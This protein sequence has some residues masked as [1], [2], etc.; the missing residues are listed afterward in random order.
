MK[1]QGSGWRRGG[2]H[3]PGDIFG[4]YRKPSS[5]VSQL[6]NKKAASQNSPT[7]LAHKW[8]GIL[9]QHGGDPF[10]GSHHSPEHDLP[11]PQSTFRPLY[12]PPPTGAAGGWAADPKSFIAC[13][14]PGGMD[15]HGHTLH[16]SPVFLPDCDT[17][18]QKGG[19]VWPRLT[20]LGTDFCLD[21]LHLSS[22]RGFPK[23]C[24]LFIALKVGWDCEPQRLKGVPGKDPH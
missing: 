14:L 4:A 3:T 9:E 11:D 24:V 8:R 19:E 15:S 23:F 17:V 6:R 7:L 18:G 21:F 2:G 10:Q 20:G 22:G 5:G 16:L 1:V 12:P 13:E